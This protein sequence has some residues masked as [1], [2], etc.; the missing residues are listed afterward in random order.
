MAF[1]GTYAFTVNRDQILKG[2]LR[3][4]GA[5]ASGETP[6]SD[7]MSDA[8]EALNLFVVHL[9]TYGIQI[10]AVT[11][12]TLFLQLDQVEYTLGLSGDHTTQ[13][14][15]T[16]TLS[17]AAVSGATS[18]TVTSATGITSGDN[19]GVVV[20]DGTIH[21]TTAT[22][23]G[24][25]LTLATG[26][27]DDAASGNRV[28]AYTSKAIRPIDIMSARLH[29]LDSG[30]DTPLTEFD[31]I[32]YRELPNKTTE[33]TVNGFFFDRRRGASSSAKFYVW[34]EPDSVD[35]VVKYTF[36]RP[37]QD[38]T[39]ASD[40]P[41]MPGD[42]YL[43]LMYNVA[44]LLAPEYDVPA[45]KFAIIKSEADKYLNQAIWHERELETIEL[46]P[47]R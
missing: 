21:W 12:A 46:V 16:T 45:D 32:E 18:V 35:D 43:P 29:N 5:S 15:V 31:R 27:D 10:W 9:Q 22:V 36:R 2:A 17:A 3:K 24:S 41:D 13:S 1:S 34:P 23:S 40:N 44:V 8:N 39:A 7:T 37:Y 6:D 20:D 4:I 47:D 38:A 30:I 42:W 28:I 19:V 33:A 14:Y 25:T 26:I 11:E